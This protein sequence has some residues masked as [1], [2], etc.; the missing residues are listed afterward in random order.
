[1]LGLCIYVC[2]GVCVFEGRGLWRPQTV[3]DHEH[4]EAVSFR[5]PWTS[6]LPRSCESCDVSMLGTELRSSSRVGHAFY[7]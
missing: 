6:D 5:R 4:R 1:M 2:G 3:G 7:R